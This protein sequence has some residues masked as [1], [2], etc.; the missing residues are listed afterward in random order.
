MYIL[1]K[2]VLSKKLTRILLGIA[3][4]L[5]LSGCAVGPDFKSP[6]APRGSSYLKGGMPKETLLANGGEQNF[7]V[8]NLPSAE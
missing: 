6:D 4:L 1:V 5:G 3:I 8:G 7:T 2:L